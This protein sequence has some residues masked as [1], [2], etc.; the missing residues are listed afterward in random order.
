MTFPQIDAIFGSTFNTSEGRAPAVGLNTAAFVSG[1]ADSSLN[2]KLYTDAATVDA[3]VTAADLTA[4][5]GAQIKAILAQGIRVGG[6][7]LI[8]YDGAG[9]G[10]P[11][12]GLTAAVTAGILPGWSYAAIVVQA[13][14]DATIAS[15]STWAH[16]NARGRALVF[17]QLS[18][19]SILSGTK[20][21]GVAASSGSD[22]TCVCF[23]PTNTATTIESA[24]GWILTVDPT[25]SRAGFGI[26]RPLGLTAYSTELT[27]PESALA[28]GRDSGQASCWITGPLF[29]ADSR[30]VVRQ[31]YTVGGTLAEVEWGVIV[32]EMQSVAAVASFVA[33]RTE[34]QNPIRTV[35]GDADA[36]NAAI[37]PVF[38]AG[39]ANGFLEPGVAA[40]LATGQPALPAGYIL[41]PR[42]VGT[43][44][45][46]TGW[47]AYPG[48][49]RRIN[50]TVTGVVT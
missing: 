10:T 16:T 29:P 32:L 5:A 18:T 25:Q 12:T 8:V 23:D 33:S 4:Q 9:V 1:D 13:R 15:A 27:G 49:V 41:T 43:D 47:A 6:V 44:L 48:D 20:P 3:D 39:A 17:G 22:I 19:S 14:V 28:S 30:R 36:A 26:Q 45:N 37:D 46:F 34:L 50:L 21:A 40:N 38:K 7:R 11:A 42:F 24:V 2:L 31:G 35:Q